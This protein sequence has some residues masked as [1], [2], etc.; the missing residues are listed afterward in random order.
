[1]EGRIGYAAAG[2]ECSCDNKNGTAEGTEV[3]FI[4][5]HLILT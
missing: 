4:Y 5:C 2:R 1:M 3:A